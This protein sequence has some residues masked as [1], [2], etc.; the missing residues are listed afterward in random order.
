MAKR[1]SNS[2][3]GHGKPARSARKRP[4]GAEHHHIQRVDN[5]STATFC[6]K[7]QLKRKGGVTHKYFTDNVFGGKSNALEAAKAWRD[8]LLYANSGPE[9]AMWRRNQMRSHNTSGIVGVGRYVRYYKSDHGVRKEPRWQAYWKDADGKRQSRWFPVRDYG[10]ERAKWL[11]C[12][13]REE[14]MEQTRRELLRRGR[15][16]LGRGLD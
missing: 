7:V 12:R 8:A 15:I 13:A 3:G 10:E 2:T 4:E 6:W 9:Y 5:P 14:G 11:A 16:V 1:K